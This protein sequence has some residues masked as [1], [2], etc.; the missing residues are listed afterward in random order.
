MNLYNPD[1]RVEYELW[2]SSVLDLSE[3][4]ISSIG[5]FQS[6]FGNDALFTPRILTFE[7]TLCPKEIREKDCLSDGRYCPY[8][9]KNHNDEEMSR[10]DEDSNDASF[11]M[12]KLQD[13]HDE[14]QH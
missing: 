5:K 4:L 14:K 9:P 13:D 10:L 3:P 7:C 1:N 8:R 11:F 12:D 6:R 2:Y